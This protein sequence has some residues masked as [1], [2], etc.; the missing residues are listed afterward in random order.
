MW[1]LSVILHF[2]NFFS[3][4]QKRNKVSLR[5]LSVVK[6]QV[7]T[8]DA[9]ERRKLL[10]EGLQLAKE[11]LQLDPSDGQ[12]WLILGNALLSVAFYSAH[13]EACIQ[14]ALSAYGQAEKYDLARRNF[15]SADLYFNKAA[16]K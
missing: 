9:E 11:A 6:R 16:V 1:M 3:P 15:N 5:N 7:S 8:K 13:N 14:K 12:S 10:F 2:I 4:I